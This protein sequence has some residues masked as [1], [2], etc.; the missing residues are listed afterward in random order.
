MTSAI[1]L[2]LFTTVSIFSFTLDYI[3]MCGVIGADF[4]AQEQ[5]SRYWAEKSVGVGRL[6][7]SFIQTQAWRHRDNSLT[8]QGGFWY[9][10]G[11]MSMVS[12][13]NVC[14]GFGHQVVFDGLCQD[15]LPEIGALTDPF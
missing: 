10:V 1:T 7:N 6:L 12:L 15:F 8:R 13:Q 11:S 5:K 9:A 14:K 2:L 4:A 3:G